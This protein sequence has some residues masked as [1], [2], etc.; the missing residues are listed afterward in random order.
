[1]E[2]PDTVLVLDDEASI[3]L[4]VRTVLESHGFQ[5]LEATRCEEA[6]II[7]RRTRPDAI[8]LDYLL[9]DGDALD[10]MGKIRDVDAEV[11]IILLTAHGSIDLAVRAVKQGAEY[12]FTK[13]VELPALIVVLQRAL[14]NRRARRRELADRSDGGKK[15]VDPFLGASAV[16]RSLRDQ[17]QKL[18]QSDRPVLVVGETGSGKGV[19]ARWLHRLG[20]RSKAAFVDINCASLSREL[21]ES[22]LFGHAK[23]A[24]TGAD[25]RK[26]GLLEV[27]HRGTLF[28]DEIGD[29]DQAVQPKLLTVIE[30]MRF[31]RLGEVRDLLVDVRI[32]AATHR[33]LADRVQRQLFRADLYFRISALPLR[34]PAL[35]ERVEDIPVLADHVMERISAELG[36][37]EVELTPAAVIALQAYAWPGNIRELRNVLERALLLTD[38]RKI[39]PQDLVFETS[40]R[41][42]AAIVAPGLDTTLA[43][44]ERSHILRVLEAEE[45]N[46]PQ[47]ARRLGIPRSTLYQRLKSYDIKAPRVDPPESDR[48]SR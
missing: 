10:L 30:E 4:A 39:G 13:P 2:R 24:F 45:G 43:E 7:F 3:R 36:K 44:L 29:V 38:H 21:L 11:P 16:I 32:I 27:A 33:D 8:I 46:V 17:A 41:P 6:A 18:L 19:V 14:E 37:G 40:A 9:P 23:G 22:E 5:T 42:V 26:M 35:R 12:F 1:M 47:A 34:V 25:A 20:P 31:R 48:A 15:D 28:L